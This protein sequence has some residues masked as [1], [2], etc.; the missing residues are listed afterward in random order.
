M[1]VYES[2]GF[3]HR[4]QYVLPGLLPNEWGRHSAIDGRS[5]T[6]QSRTYLAAAGR[7]IAEKGFHTLVPLMRQLPA[8]EL[9]IAGSGPAEPLLRRLAGPLPNV[10]FEGLLDHDRIRLLF[11]NARA[12]IVPSLFQE[13][14]GMVPAEA[15]GLGVPV[16]ARNRGSLP[17]LIEATSGGLTFDNETELVEQMGRIVSD[18][19]LFSRLHD[20]SLN[21]VPPIWFEKSHADSYL[22]IIAEISPKLNI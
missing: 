1:Q 18:D 11:Q 8:V 17:E 15:M 22:Q 21:R 14:F 5:I 13:T 20:A 10:K 3:S 16:L 9:R 12:V 4:R 7:L 2:R 19:R 6:S